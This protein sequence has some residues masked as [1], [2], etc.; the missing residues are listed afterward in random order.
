MIRTLE[1]LKN[2]LF[3]IFVGIVY[4]FSFLRINVGD[5]FFRSL[6][7]NYPLFFHNSYGAYPVWFGFEPAHF[8]PIPVLRGIQIF[9]ANFRFLPDALLLTQ[10]VNLLLALLTIKLVYSLLLRLNVGNAIAQLTSILFAFS[11]GFYANIN[12]EL[13][14]FSVCLF[15]ALIWL[16]LDV[17]TKPEPGKAAIFSASL[18]LT[19][20]PLFHSE[21]IIFSGLAFIY[22]LCKKSL[23]SKFLTKPIAV[24][25]GLVIIPAILILSSMLF[26]YFEVGRP[27][28][29]TYLAKYLLP[30]WRINATQNLFER[31]HSS[32]KPLSAY[33][34]SRAHL[35]SFSIVS[36]TAKILQHYKDIIFYSNVPAV[37]SE[38]AITI[39]YIISFIF[40]NIIGLTLAIK[41][42]AKIPGFIWLLAAMLVIYLF[43]F[44]LLVSSVFLLSEFF[45][46]TAM[47]Q[48]ILLGY[49]FNMGRKYQKSL[50]IFLVFITAFSNIAFFVYPQ[51][52]SGESISSILKENKEKVPETALFRI[53]LFEF[54]YGNALGNK[55]KV[56]FDEHAYDTKKNTLEYADLIN[57]ELKQG[58]RVVLVSPGFLFGEDKEVN[59]GSVLP[60]GMDNNPALSE[61]LRLLLKT[62]NNNYRMTIAKK[63][64]YNFAT[65]GQLGRL[66]VVELQ[67]K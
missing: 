32:I 26:H 25:L 33:I 20:M 16:I 27:D 45:I 11:Y 49:L 43:S 65:L 57:N 15:A 41:N 63:Y 30:N 14:H 7:N 40:V 1:N 38:V 50:F 56:H 4:Y 2:N 12:G 37:N 31:A 51:K 55:L 39:G 19:L 61:N 24:I 21:T 52:I 5:S 10:M 18:C 3:I 17:D 29:D 66:A 13:H 64:S 60:M 35:E 44:G 28:L 59:I 67:R 62:L 8:L 9:I 6:E 46:I 58:K 34:M 42:R 54:P 48:C 36:R 22:I 23:R 53:S 47:I